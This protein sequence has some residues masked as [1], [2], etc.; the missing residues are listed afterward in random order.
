MVL[1]E[2]ADESYAVQC[3]TFFLEPVGVPPQRTTRRREG[4]SDP[5]P[6]AS[7]TS[8]RVGGIPRLA[9]G[10]WEAKRVL[11][12]IRTSR[13]ELYCFKTLEWGFVESLHVLD[14]ICLTFR[15]SEL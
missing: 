15:I 14:T 6:G 10:F 8:L 11:D 12:E 9:S 3:R 7:G 2:P 1:L 5:V 4:C 13:K